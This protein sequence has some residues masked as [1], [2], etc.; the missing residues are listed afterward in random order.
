[1][2][3]VFNSGLLT[4]GAALF[5][6]LSAA[7]HKNTTAEEEFNPTAGLTK[8]TEGYAIG[9]A[10]KVEVWAQE[11]LSTGYNK[12][13]FALY[14]SL[15]NKRITESQIQIKPI[16]KMTKM[17][18]SCPKEEPDSKA[19]D[20]L[21]PC[22]IMFSMPSNETGK[23][24]LETTVRN[25]TKVGN[26]VFDINVAV[27]DPSRMSFIKTP[28]DTTWFVSCFF[29]EK[30]KTGINTFEIIVFKLKKGEPNYLPA[31]NL[32][33]TFTP[34]MPDMGHGSSNNENPAHTKGGH[35]Q[36]K[37]NF[38]MTGDWKLEVELSD[39]KNTSIGK[40]NFTVKVSQ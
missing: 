12:V 28:Q 36:G 16:M 7:C 37:V 24:T 17:S 11:G 15:T 20:Q 34:T 6:I 1:M 10:A 18:H 26:P 29:P 35:Y 14:D 40:T 8:I 39:K 30:K 9:A 21:F 38:S 13:W 33:I 25:N 31:A 5:I 32:Q 19:V 2:K 23:W 4:T 3:S 22:G 27:S